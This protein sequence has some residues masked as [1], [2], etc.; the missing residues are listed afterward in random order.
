MKRN[1]APEPPR[2]RPV[3]ATPR[4]Y[5]HRAGL[6]LYQLMEKS[7]TMSS[8]PRIPNLLN[9][10]IKQLDTLVPFLGL[11]HAPV[12]R[13]VQSHETKWFTAE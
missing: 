4:F 9:R 10:L 5:S 12:Y 7:S 1:E 11:T 13:L 8:K 2:K 3:T 6:R